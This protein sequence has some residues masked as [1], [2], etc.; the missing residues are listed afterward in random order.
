M[1]LLLL[2]ACALRS[3]L[4]IMDAEQAVLAAERAGAAE[5]AVR[6]ATLAR[7]YLDE[8]QRNQGQ[9]RYK[10]AETLADQA[11]VFA[12]QAGKQA[13]LGASGGQV[14]PEE[15]T[16]EVVAPPPEPEAPGEEQELMEVM[17]KTAEPTPPPEEK[18]LDTEIFEDDSP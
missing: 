16:P 5:L 6:D 2:T 11:R 15:K 14:V 8:A 1:L 17:E 13:T 18:K 9:A 7:A 12:E 10:A 3:T 4:A